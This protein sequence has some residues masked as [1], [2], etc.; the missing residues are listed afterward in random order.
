MSALYTMQYQGQ[1]GSGGGA[2][3]IGK[4][5][6]LGVD[7]TGARYNGSYTTTPAGRLQGTVTLTSSGATLVTGQQ[8]PAGTQIPI[9]LDL[10]ANFANGQFQQVLVS[11]GPVQVR[12][13]KIG[14]I[15]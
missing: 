9:T 2:V 6:V 12:F 10:P 3:Y 1:V 11:G 4:G 8:V 15:P 14:D 13:D 7:V 5:I